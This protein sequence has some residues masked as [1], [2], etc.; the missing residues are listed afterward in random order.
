[1]L[2]WRACADLIYKSAV[3]AVLVHLAARVLVEAYLSL[4]RWLPQVLEAFRGDLHLLRRRRE[5][6]I[7]GL[8]E[9]QKGGRR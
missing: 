2:S 5:A 4:E 9:T 6:L 8:L 7:I 1:M 3:E